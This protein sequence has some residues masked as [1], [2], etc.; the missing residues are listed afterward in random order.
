VVVD[1]T[2]PFHRRQG[3][4]IRR[5]NADQALVDEGEAADDS[6][7]FGHCDGRN[8]GGCRE[9][10]GK[11]PRCYGLTFFMEIPSRSKALSKRAQP[12]G[13]TPLQMTPRLGFDFPMAEHALD[14]VAPYPRQTVYDGIIISG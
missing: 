8:G 9:S 11:Q 1:R 5:A 13:W 3:R 7:I 10:R 6:G 2:F 14:F 12:A 4:R